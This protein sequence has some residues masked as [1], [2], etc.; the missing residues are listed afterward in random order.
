M[1]G[2]NDA[3]MQGRVRIGMACH[4]SVTLYIHR[5]WHALIMAMNNAVSDISSLTQVNLCNNSHA[6]PY[7]PHARLFT[8]LSKC[9]KVVAMSAASSHSYRSPQVGPHY[10]SG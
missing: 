8:I 4:V 10:K 7:L 1:K 9:K 6:T 5:G 2:K 3:R